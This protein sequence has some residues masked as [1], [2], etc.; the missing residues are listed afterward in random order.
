MSSSGG[1]FCLLHVN[2]SLCSNHVDTRYRINLK[3]ASCIYR[4]CFPVLCSN[5]GKLLTQGR[6][7]YQTGLNELQRTT[8]FSL[9]QIRTCSCKTC[10]HWIVFF[11]VIYRVGFIRKTGSNCPSQQFKRMKVKSL[12]SNRTIKKC[13]SFFG[14]RFFDFTTMFPGRTLFFKS[15]VLSLWSNI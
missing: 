8:S 10:R 1:C 7:L 6:K 13:F 15:L 2:A 9:R 3:T 4:E 12:I 14:K 5:C 11:G